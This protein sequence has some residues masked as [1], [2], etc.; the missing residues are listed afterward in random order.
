MSVNTFEHNTNHICLLVKESPTII[1]HNS[2]VI[3]PSEYP[4]QVVPGGVRGGARG[5]ARGVPGGVPG[6]TC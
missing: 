4:S 5:G 1:H 6:P 2:A 3:S